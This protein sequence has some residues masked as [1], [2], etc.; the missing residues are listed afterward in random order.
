MSVQ[1]AAALHSCA[2]SSCWESTGCVHQQVQ[3]VAAQNEVAAAQQVA[4][5][6]NDEAVSLQS[7]L[8]ESVDRA[9]AQQGKISQLEAQVASLHRQLQADQVVMN[10]TACIIGSPVQV[11][12]GVPSAAQYRAQPIRWL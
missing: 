6:A 5:R 1:V 8:Q 7:S 9:D 10:V 2:T 11:T 4:S 12:E 3:A